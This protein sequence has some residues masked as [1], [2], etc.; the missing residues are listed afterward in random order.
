MKWLG[1]IGFIGVMVGTVLLGAPGIVFATGEGDEGGAAENQTVCNDPE[2]S[3]DLKEAAGC[4]TET[5]LMPVVTGVIQVVLGLIGILSVAVMV[6]GGFTYLTSTG[7]P[8]KTTK[9]RNILLYGVVGIVVAGL[10]Y[11]IVYFVSRVLGG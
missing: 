2:I 4:N 5:T 9:A 11:A 1:R 6:Y 8:A 3:E 10:A 7:N